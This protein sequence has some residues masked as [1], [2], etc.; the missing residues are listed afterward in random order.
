MIPKI[1][2]SITP[3]KWL[4]E[5]IHDHIIKD[6]GNIESIKIERFKPLPSFISTLWKRRGYVVKEEGVVE[7]RFR[8]NPNI[9]SYP[10]AWLPPI[11]KNGKLKYPKKYNYNGGNDNYDK[12]SGKR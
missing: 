8:G 3:E 12:N 11:D 7:I 10:Y 5:A 2:K 1:T 6:N 4:K 9:Y